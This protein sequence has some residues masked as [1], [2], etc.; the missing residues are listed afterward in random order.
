MYACQLLE[1]QETST[2]LGMYGSGLF[3][4]GITRLGTEYLTN[5]VKEA[6]EAA[7]LYD[8]YL[9][10]GEYGV[11]SNAPGASIIQ[12][13]HDMNEVFETYGIGRAAWTYK[14]KSF[15]ISDEY[16]DDVTVDVIQY[17]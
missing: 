5:L 3:I 1:Y 11:I 12:W 13:F 4:D 15:G 10:C 8:A 2:K 14:S 16:D 6:V 17:L 9:Y 7:D